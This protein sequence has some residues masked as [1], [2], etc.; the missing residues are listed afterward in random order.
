MRTTLLALALAV[1][2]VTAGVG[3]AV[4]DGSSAHDTDVL[5][6]DHAIDVVDPADD[7]AVADVTAA[8]ETAWTDDEV[9]AA[10]DDSAPLEFEVWADP[11]T[12]TDADVAVW[13]T[14]RDDQANA[15]I[16]DVDLGTEMVLDVRE[17]I[18]KTTM[19][20]D[21]VDLAVVDVGDLGGEV[22]FSIENG[23]AV[24]RAGVMATPANASREADGTVTLD[25]ANSL[26]WPLDV[27]A[28]LDETLL[29]ASL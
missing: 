4:A 2:A 25:A 18:T 17:P 1:A 7:L 11:A 14:E 27:P 15:T 12:D 13:I 16:A 5:P 8:V 29:T 3:G 22:T 20:T 19:H 6:D 28:A 24:D 9:R 10:V 23:T 21:R 26:Q